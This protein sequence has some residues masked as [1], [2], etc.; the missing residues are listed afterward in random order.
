MQQFMDCAQQLGAEKFIKNVL[1]GTS[2]EVVHLAE[3]FA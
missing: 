3:L 2:Q 1:M